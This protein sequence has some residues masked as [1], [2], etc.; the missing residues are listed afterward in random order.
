MGEAQAFEV[1]NFIDTMDDLKFV[2]IL[3]FMKPFSMAISTGRDTLFIIILF[4][5]SI[6]IKGA[7]FLT[8]DPGTRFNID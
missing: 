4:S 5:L 7:S 2:E 3:Y 1:L 6:H 8:K